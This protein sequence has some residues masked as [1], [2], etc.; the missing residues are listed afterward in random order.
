MDRPQASAKKVLASTIG[1]AQAVE[2]SDRNG[3]GL[4]EVFGRRSFCPKTWSRALG[5]DSYDPKPASQECSP[6]AHEVGEV[7]QAPFQKAT[8]LGFSFEWSRSVRHCNDPPDSKGCGATI[9]RHPHDT[10]NLAA[11]L[12]RF[13]KE[14]WHPDQP[15][16]H[17]HGTGHHWT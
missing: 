9:A 15:W 16:H 13:Q 2:F 12:L 4:G 10:S 7:Q 11:R 3:D 6:M 1:A 14:P 17:P 8:A 5:L